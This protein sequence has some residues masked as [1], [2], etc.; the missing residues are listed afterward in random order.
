MLYPA[1][2]IGVSTVTF[3][4]TSPR[5]DHIRVGWF[6]RKHGVYK[7]GENRE[8]EDSV[9]HGADSIAAYDKGTLDGSSLHSL[10]DL[11]GIHAFGNRYR[12]AP[13]SFE[14]L[15]VSYMGDWLLPGKIIRGHTHINQTLG[16]ACGAEDN[17]TG[18]IA[19]HI[20]GNQSQLM[21]Q[22]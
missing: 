17:Y 9:P 12:F 22:S 2:T 15:P 4:K 8:F 18:T 7:H 11:D 5:K 19:P 20:T 14:S 21:Q 6:F 13:D 1:F 3:G 10:Y 16:I